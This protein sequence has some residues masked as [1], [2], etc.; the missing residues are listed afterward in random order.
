MPT[1][2]GE[3]TP[4]WFDANAHHEPSK[5]YRDY[6][7]GW[8]DASR[9]QVGIMREGVAEAENDA[10]SGAMAQQRGAMAQ[11]TRA[12]MSAGV[13]RGQSLLA[14]RQ[15]MRSLGANQGTAMQQGSMLRAQET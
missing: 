1:W 13:G 9:R 11:A 8:S 12:G 6:A 5:F 14:Q 7:G 10:T 4:T 3:L 15:G 2:R